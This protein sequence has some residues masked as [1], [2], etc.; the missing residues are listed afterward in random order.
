MPKISEISAT[1]G[2]YIKLYKADMSGLVVCLL[3]PVAIVQ[4]FSV[5]K[6]VKSFFRLK[7]TF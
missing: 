2:Q 4:R 3:T 6:H 5:A 1:W 7:T